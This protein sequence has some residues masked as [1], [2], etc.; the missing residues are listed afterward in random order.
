MSDFAIEVS[1]AAAKVFNKTVAPQQPDRNTLVIEEYTSSYRYQIYVRPSRT[2]AWTSF[3]SVQT[4]TGVNNATRDASV[5]AEGAG[6]YYH[7]DAVMKC[8]DARYDVELD[9]RDFRQT[10]GNEFYTDLGPRVMAQFVSI[11]PA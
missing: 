6:G 7:Y 1:K 9:L 3:D 10:S 2:R 5:A 4:I 8:F 11:C